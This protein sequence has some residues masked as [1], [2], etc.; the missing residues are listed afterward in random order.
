M[1]DGEVG[2]ES[3]DQSKETEANDIQECSCADCGERACHET[4]PCQ[5]VFAFDAI[6]RTEMNNDSKKVWMVLATRTIEKPLR[7][8]CLSG[9]HRVSHA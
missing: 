2:E 8:L 1:L 3:R 6:Y 5:G 7:F 9:F 4:E